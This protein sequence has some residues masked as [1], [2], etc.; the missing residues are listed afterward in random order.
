MSSVMSMLSVPHYKDNKVKFTYTNK[1]HYAEESQAN[2]IR[3]A[4]LSQDKKGDFVN[5]SAWLMCKDFFNDYVVAYN[6]GPKFSIYGFSTV[7]MYIPKLGEPV[8]IAV[9]GLQTHFHANL[10]VLNNY[11]FSKGMPYVTFQVVPNDENVT[12]LL[13]D[14]KYLLCTYNISLLSLIIR[15][16]N[17]GIAFKDWNSFLSCT[18]FNH[19]DQPKIEAIIK[20]GVFFD[21]PEA[22]AKF[23]WYAGPKYNSGVE[24]PVYQMSGLVHNSGAVS[25][26]DQL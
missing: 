18:K 12:I 13:I 19:R 10:G 7:N 4:I 1:S 5:E 14:P 11:L 9:K 17:D 15:C 3:W 24:V 26:T 6:G 25:M 8:F 22:I 21:L 16:M 20:K 23:T 2:P